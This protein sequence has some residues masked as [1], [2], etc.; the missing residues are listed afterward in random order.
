MGFPKL[1]I[2]TRIAIKKTTFTMSNLLPD[3]T[4][5]MNDEI[6]P[7]EPPP[8]YSEFP[9]EAST[10]INNNNE[11]PTNEHIHDHNS[12]M[13]EAFSPSPHF[14][15]AP[16][17]HPNIRSHFPFPNE[18]PFPPS[19]PHHITPPNVHLQLPFIQFSHPN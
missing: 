1:Y 16:I 6:E 10:D 7:T 8:P 19:I 13:P 11:Q 12:S 5:L 2:K 14:T 17:P 9:T 15:Q 18:Y 4:T 3:R